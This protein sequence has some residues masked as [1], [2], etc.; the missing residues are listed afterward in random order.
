MCRFPRFALGAALVLAVLS[1]SLSPAAA[2]NVCMK[3]TEL[4]G[5]L[6]KH[7]ETPAAI[8]LASNGSLIEVFATADGATWSIVMTSP[9]G[10]ACVVA[11]GEDWDQRMVLQ[12]PAA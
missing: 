1:A 7:Q 2:R 6:E 12:A 9:Q 11:V 8:G 10:V 3:R 4:T 5:V